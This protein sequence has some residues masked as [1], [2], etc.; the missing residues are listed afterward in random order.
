MMI[1]QGLGEIRGTRLIQVQAMWIEIGQDRLV[2]NFTGKVYSRSGNWWEDNQDGK[3]TIEIV[4]GSQ[5]MRNQ[6]LGQEIDERGTG[7]ERSDRE[8]D[9]DGDGDG[10]RTGEAQLK[11]VREL[12]QKKV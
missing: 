10:D 12:G 4:V 6:R 11:K 3:A 9:R 7:A 2:N 1:G 5:G 8:R